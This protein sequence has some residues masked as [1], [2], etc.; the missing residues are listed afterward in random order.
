MFCLPVKEAGGVT[1]KKMKCKKGALHVHVHV[2]VC[3]SAI[4][5]YVALP[6][7]IHVH[8]HVP[9]NN[10]I[11]HQ[12]TERRACDAICA[13]KRIFK[14]LFVRSLPQRIFAY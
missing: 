4:Y 12:M 10:D 5:M 11:I 9:N 6:L 3:V 13:T 1:V 14:I 7:I 2:H 8:V